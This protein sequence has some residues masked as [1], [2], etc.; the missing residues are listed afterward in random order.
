M[1]PDHVA[2]YRDLYDRDWRWRAQERAVGTP[3]IPPPWPNRLL[4]TVTALD[5]RHGRG[6]GLPCR[7]SLIA[8]LRRAAAGPG[9]GAS[10][11]QGGIRDG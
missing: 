1:Q 7:S 3:R 10:M 9:S 4:E 11:P 5:L 2:A 6:W 8:V